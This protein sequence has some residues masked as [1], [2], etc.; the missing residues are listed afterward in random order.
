MLLQSE[1]TRKVFGQTVKF[2]S[3]PVQSSHRDEYR[4]EEEFHHPE[5]SYARANSQIHKYQSNHLFF[6]RKLPNLATG[7]KETVRKTFASAQVIHIT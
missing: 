6:P 7:N 4:G 1:H 5:Q 2:L 3:Y